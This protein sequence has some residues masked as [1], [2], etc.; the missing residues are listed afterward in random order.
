MK[1]LLITDNHSPT[2]G[3]ENYF[4]ALK[5]KLKD[6]PDVQV[7]S[8]GFGKQA[9]YGADY[10]VFKGAR[11]AVA[12]LL[13]RILPHPLIY[14]RLK[15]EIEAIAPDLIHLHN[16]KQYSLAV[17]KAIKP[18]PV[19][20][21]IHDYGAVCPVA[22]NIHQNLQPCASGFRLRCFWQ[23][24]LK[25]PAPLYL[26]FVYA[27]YQLTY[28][29]KKTATVFFTPSPQ[30]VDYLSRNGYARATYIP[31]F[32]NQPKS[33]AFDKIKIGHFLFAGN[34]GTHKG[35]YILLDEFKL[36]LKQNATLKL[37][38]L[39]DGPLFT[40][41]QKRIQQLNLEDHVYLAGWQADPAPFYET[42]MCILFPSIWMEAFGLVITE[43]MSYARPVIG[44]NRGS[45]P[46][47]IE[48]N[49]TGYLFDP[50]K[51]GD[52]AEKI[53]RMAS[54]P[55]QSMQLGKA[56]HARLHDLF[57]DDQTMATILKHYEHCISLHKSGA[58]QNCEDLP[59]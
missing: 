51:K 59:R 41:L 6:V 14:K 33:F 17:L 28:H 57:N 23:H 58:G 5:E 35:V 48:N 9:E 25:H 18:Y 32:K 16:V 11:S 56:G 21:T 36:A 31:P 38:I 40:P 1:I 24:H 44:S 3:A 53:I 42:A 45:P 26:A 10:R 8:L 46:W 39:G 2:G 43:A 12:K 20:Q 29:L 49:Q 47:L 37:T 34:L 55:A 7:F 19:V 54:N 50:L 22:Y 13:G 52:L 30:L 4:F 27:F 15:K